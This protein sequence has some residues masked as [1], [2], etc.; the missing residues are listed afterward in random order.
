MATLPLPHPRVEDDDGPGVPGLRRRGRPPAFVLVAIALAVGGVVLVWPT[1]LLLWALWTTDPLK[2]IGIFVPWISLVLMLRTWRAM[3]WEARGTWW[4]LALLLLTAAVVHLRDHALLELVIGPSWAITL[5]PHSLVAFAYASSVVLLFG[6]TRLWRAAWFPVVL[7]LLVNPVPHVF[8]TWIDLP[9]QHA[10]AAIARGVAHALGQHLSPDQ[11]YL[12]F[13]P[14]FGMFIA[15]GCDGIRGAVTMGLIALVAGYLYRFRLRAWTLVLAG[16][17]LLGYVFNLLRLCVLVLY[18]VLALHLPGLR[19]HA[20]AADYC[21]GASL[22]FAATMCLF[23]AIRRFSS[24][25]ELH[26]PAPAVPPPAGVPPLKRAAMSW[27]LAITAAITLV[28]AA[29]LLWAATRA[30]PAAAFKP[31]PFPRQVGDYQLRRTWPERLDTG[32]TIFEWAEYARRNTSAAI[33]VGVS[34]VLGAHDVLLCHVARGESWQWHGTLVL[35]SVTAPV[36]FGATYF[37][38]GETAA[39]EASTVCTGGQ[40]GQWSSPRRHLGLIYSPLPPAGAWRESLGPIPV[41]L[42]TELPAR[43][44]STSVSRLLLEVQMRQFVAHTTFAVF[45]RGL[46]QP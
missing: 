14:D 34:P 25:R 46:R 6:G 28:T 15:P 24:G 11:L 23:A 18:Y 5:P 37:N 10:A 19:G 22:F 31:V 35:P 7:M 26:L 20:E 32:Q 33:Q 3:D 9:L 40:C 41:L 21:I 30:S 2:S 44:T 45:T 43:G 29:P 39:L 8:N 38:D 27:R 16:A 1:A 36:S 17:V 4:G 42:R 12:M 13:T